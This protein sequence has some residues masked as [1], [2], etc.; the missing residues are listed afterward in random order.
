VTPLFGHDEAVAAF[1]AGLDG[2]RLHHAW[3]VTGPEGVGKALFAD[4]AALRV[5]AEGAGMPVAMAGIDVPDE[6]PTAKLV[7]AGSHPDLMRL[8]RL[9]KESGT[10]LAPLDNGRPDQKPAAPVHDHARHVALARGRDRFGR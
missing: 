8:E 2:G 7:A 6:H 5:L 1:R 3:L 10:E 9:T 4:K